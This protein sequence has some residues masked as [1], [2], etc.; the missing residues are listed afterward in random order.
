MIRITIHFFLLQ[1]LTVL[2]KQTR[3]AVHT[4]KQSIVLRFY[5]ITKMQTK[6]AGVKVYLRQTLN[7][8]SHAVSAYF[9][10]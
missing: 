3:Q 2:M 7:F 1:I 9:G 4:I 5:G 8:R 10:L 6:V